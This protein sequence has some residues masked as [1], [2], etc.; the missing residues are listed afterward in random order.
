MI[1]LMNTLIRIKLDY[2]SV[3]WNN[4]ILTDSN[5][6]ENIGLQRN[7][8]FCVISLHFDILGNFRTF[9]HRRI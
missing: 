1:M 9:I 7:L 6:V 8:P 3:I 2:S 5:K 4:L